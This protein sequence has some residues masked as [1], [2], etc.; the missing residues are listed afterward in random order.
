M[1]K[2]RIIMTGTAIVS[3]GVNIEANNRKEA[4]NKALEMA[5][6]GDVV[7]NYREL[8]D[9]DRILVQYLRKSPPPQNV[10]GG[11]SV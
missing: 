1:M 9:G 7:W 8:V 4:E 3:A 11:Q 5:D 2:Y 10:H 6:H